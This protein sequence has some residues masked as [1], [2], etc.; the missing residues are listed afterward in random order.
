MDKKP[1]EKDSPKRLLM[2]PAVTMSRK[3]LSKRMRKFEGAT[4]RHARKFVFR[5]LNNMRE[6]RRHILIWAVLVAYV[7][8]ATALQLAW[9]QQGYRTTAGEAGGTYAEAVKGPLD[10]LN[11]LF[12][13]SSAEQS[14]SRLLFSS[15]M[16]YDT[17]GHLNY[18]LATNMK[19]DE[20]RKVYTVKIQPDAQWHDKQPITA[21]DVVFTI[22]LIKDP[23]VRSTI[24]GWNSIDVKAIDRETVQFTLPAI[25]AAF[26]HYLTF[27]IVPEHLLKN[28][29]PAALRENS[30]SVDPTGSGPFVFRL[31]QDIET[32]NGRKVLHL[33]RNNDYFGGAPK[34]ERFQLD[35]YGSD[36]A[37]QRALTTSEVNAAVDLTITEAAEVDR[38][39]YNV[40]L[41]PIDAGVYALFNT[42]NSQLQEPSLRKALQ[43]GTDTAE[44][45]KVFGSDLP[46]DLYLPFV[47]G[48]VDGP[49][50]S[51]PV[52]DPKTANE[53]LES[54]GWKLQDGVRKKDGATLRLNVVVIKN[55]DFEKIT[56]ALVAQW[57]KLGVLASITIADTSDST[58][59]VAQNILQPRNFD[60]LIYQLATSADPDVYVYW[61]SSQANENGANYSNY[62]N[63]LS[64]E[65]LSSARSRVETDL[66]AAKYL[67]FANQWLN[68]VPAIGLYQATTQYVSNRNIRT[69]A[70]NDHL[71]LPTDRYA[72]LLYWTVNNKSVFTTP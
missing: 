55:P 34:L 38:T 63:T 26:P 30:F 66:R 70:A 2:L 61:H 1:P 49:M 39:R 31:L 62:T 68:D 16:A 52:Y 69:I 27:P 8:A 53:L 21:S 57:K 65:A 48:Q 11:P 58:Q 47:N 29:A 9:Y 35:I 41:K 6:V 23:M 14:V 15:L 60:V 43:V 71:I 13:S 56:D 51:A 24:T 37:I 5:R 50:P 20:S 12:A 25:Y 28:V 18:D 17:T 54:A 40:Q 64:D 45:R 22:N 7:I 42:T 67:V 36:A 4:V 33:V 72:G 46:P 3:E 10:T 59:R 19:L 44:L 32:T